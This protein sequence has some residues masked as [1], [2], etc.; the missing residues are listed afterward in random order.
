MMPRDR[1]LL[2]PDRH[3]RTCSTCGADCEIETE[4]VRGLGVR[5]VFTCQSHGIHAI[6]DPFA[7]LR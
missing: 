4:A 2:D 6:L 1:A 7:D 3:Y 5:I